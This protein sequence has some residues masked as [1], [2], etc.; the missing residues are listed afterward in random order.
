M[1]RWLKWMFGQPEEPNTDR[2]HEWTDRIPLDA[3]CPDTQPTS[4]GALDSD[5]GD[6]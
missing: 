2:L 4:P 1:W 6:P 3:S 5:R